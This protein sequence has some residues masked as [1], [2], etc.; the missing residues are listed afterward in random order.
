MECR[1]TGKYGP[2]NTAMSS[3]FL[4]VLH[5]YRWLISSI[6]LHAAEAA[7]LRVCVG[8][9]ETDRS[10]CSRDEKGTETVKENYYI[11]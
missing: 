9:T 7:A 4:P 6:L 8:Y 2:T 1:L 3:L 10:V 5:F 11:V